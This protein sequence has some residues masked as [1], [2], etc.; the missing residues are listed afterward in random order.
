MQN[1]DIQVP[2]STGPTQANYVAGLVYKVKYSLPEA[3]RKPTTQLAADR[4]NILRKDK[5]G[6]N[7]KELQKSESEKRGTHGFAKGR[8]LQHVTGLHLTEL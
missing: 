5:E 8:Q 4:T 1:K 7:S 2:N 6:G 3:G